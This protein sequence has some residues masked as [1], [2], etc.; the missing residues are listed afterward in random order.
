MPGFATT[1]CA[2][3][4]TGPMRQ[5]ETKAALAAGDWS[6]LVEEG[7]DDDDVSPLTNVFIKGQDV[8]ANLILFRALAHM[9]G[10]FVQGRMLRRN[11]VAPL[12]LSAK[13]FQPRVR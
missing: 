6:V 12:L 13:P 2:M 3:F 10:V 1:G 8:A 4:G 5:A 11:L 7:T 9:A